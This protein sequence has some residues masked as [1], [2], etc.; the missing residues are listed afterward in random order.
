MAVV[1]L[2]EYTPPAP[3]PV[4]VLTITFGA[5]EATA[6]FALVNSV[7]SAE[8]LKA[9]GLNP[10]ALWEDI[11]SSGFNYYGYGKAHADLQR[12]FERLKEGEDLY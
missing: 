12:C 8:I 2:T 1:K 6:L 3:K 7:N 11:R 5:E 4:Q 9:A 10:N